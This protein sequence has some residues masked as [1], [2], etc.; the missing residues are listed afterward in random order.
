VPLIHPL[1]EIVGL[2]CL[3]LAAS[4][5]VLTLVAELVWQFRRAAP[6][7]LQPQPVTVLKPLCGAEPGL[8]AHLRSFCQ[9]N[10]PEY[11]IVFGVRDPTDPALAV[12]E[13]LVAEYPSLPI[14]V[15]VN[16]QQHGSNCKISNLINM[17]ARARHDVLAMADSDTFVGPDYLS[18]VTA[19]LL[20]RNVGLVT[21]IY[22][23]VPTQGIWS[24]LGAMYINEWYVPSVLLAWLFGYRG[25]V[26]GQ[27]LCLRRDTLQAIG[28]LRAMANHLAED[29][30]LGAVIRGLGLR[31]VLSPY[32]LKAQHHEPNL[33]S[34]ARHELRWMRTIRVLRPYSFPFLF[35]TF[36]L[37]LAVFGVMLTA[38]APAISTTGWALFQATVMA[39]LALHFLNRLRGDRPPL[40]EF[41]LLPARDLLMCW[42]WGRSFFTTRVTWR[43]NEFDVDADGVMHR[44]T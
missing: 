11:Q 41:W 3:A 22:R 18:I 29:Y 31:I 28:G 14:D 2:A 13:R 1:V 16:P 6:H 12:V 35:I 25:Y 19:P 44:P 7:A 15:V 17:V 37:P 20:D 10:H 5:A 8:Y 33:D 24:R 42:A 30:R 34:L 9:Q 38:A 36:S 27:T 39:R 32:A 23:G 4:Y 40:R 26:S 43:G 21:C